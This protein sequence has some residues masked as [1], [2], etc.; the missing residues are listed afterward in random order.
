VYQYIDLYY[1]YNL[2]IAGV[3]CHIVLFIA[4]VFA[5]DVSVSYQY[6]C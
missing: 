6:G 4:C 3:F 1:N 5:V 2:T